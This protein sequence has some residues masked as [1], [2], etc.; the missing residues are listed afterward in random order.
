MEYYGNALCVSYED[1][2]DGGIVTASNYKNLVRRGKFT[3]LRQG[4][5]L[6]NCAL[7]AVDSLPEKYKAEVKKLYPDGN[8]TRLLEWVK[9]NYE[10]DQEAYSFF[11]DKGNRNVS[12]IKFKIKTIFFRFTLLHS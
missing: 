9:R 12:A 11:F 7:V 8:R 1:L 3:V 6:G 4:K 2:V 10:R 5:G